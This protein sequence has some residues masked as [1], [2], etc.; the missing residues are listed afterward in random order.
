MKRLSDKVFLF[1]VTG[2]L[3]LAICQ[4]VLVFFSVRNINTYNFSRLETVYLGDFDRNARNQVE[5]AISMLAAIDAKR[6]RGEMDI[7]QAKKLGADLLREMRYDKEGYFW[8]DTVEGVNV[9]LLGRPTEGQNRYEAVDSNGFA[10]VKAFV[11]NGSQAGGG[12]TDYMFPK[13]DETIPKPKRSYTLLFG[14]FGWV[15]GTG[16][17]IDDINST[18]SVE[19]E[20]AAKDMTSTINILIAISLGVAFVMVIASR[21]FGKQISAPIKL[22]AESI[23]DIAEGEADLTRHLDVKTNDE[24][25]KLS[26]HF[27]G[28]IEKLRAIISVVGGSTDTLSDI[29]I[30][31]AASA[32]ETAASLTQIAA[33]VESIKK[34][35]INQST[36]VTGTFSAM[37]QISKNIESLNLSIDQQSERVS[38]SSSGIEQMVANIQSVTA[39]IEKEGEFFIQLVSSSDS[40]KSK[41]NSVNELIR[42]ISSQSGNLLET[43]GVISEIASQTNL[44]AMNAAI[45]AAHAG[46]AGRGFAVVADE[47]RKLAERASEQS[48]ESARVLKSITESIAKMVSSSNDAE[49]AF[50]DVLSLIR[51]ITPLEEEIKSS[52]REQ[53]SG[54]EQV[55]EALGGINVITSEVR[56]GASEMNNGAKHILVEMKNLLQIS[57]EI[58]HSMDEISAGTQD[59]NQAVNQI[60]GLSATNKESIQKVTSEIARFKT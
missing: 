26:E 28:F 24:V 53:R 2:I 20:R 17:Y 30:S 10:Y 11:A 21:I 32:E 56:S 52:M 22:I 49:I 31:L 29:G 36:S 34:Q 60:S 44:L 59:I 46:D 12:Y 18:L 19:E 15:V 25:G 35:A 37:E 40:G 55:L 1:T 23:K 5:N 39:T 3:V 4:V 6:S 9:V 45:E 48:K 13:K 33:N 16:N 50:E 47:I 51:T 43:N 14:P 8:A 42:S 58:H 57:Q 38:S 7:E 41:L 54:S 27:N